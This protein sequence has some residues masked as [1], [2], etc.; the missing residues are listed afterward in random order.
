[1]DGLQ[2]LEIAVDG[3]QWME[4]RAWMRGVLSWLIPLFWSIL[5]AAIVANVLILVSAKWLRA[6]PSPNLRL[7][8]SLAGADAWTATLMLV[9]LVINTYLPTFHGVID[10]LNWRCYV[11]AIEMVR[12]AA[13]LTSDLHLFGLAANHAYSIARPL[14]ARVFLTP[15]RCKVRWETAF[16]GN[17]V[18][19][20]DVPFLFR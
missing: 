12:I 2:W 18:W 3:L 14:S 7:C 19:W 9:G 20:E 4:M 8:L 17:A 5:A 11:L 1:M 15:G 6:H 13:M 10:A 16:G